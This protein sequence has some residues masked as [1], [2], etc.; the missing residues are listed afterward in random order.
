MI[1]RINGTTTL[2]E[3]V[4]RQILESIAEGIYDK[5]DMLPGE[6][7]LIARTGVSRIT[8]REALKRLAEM[9]VIETRKGKGSFVLVTPS[10]LKPNESDKSIRDKAQKDFINSTKARL[11]LEPE[12]AREAARNATPEDIAEMEKTLSR[13]GKSFKLEDSFDSFHIALAKAAHNPFIYSFVEQLVAAE[14]QIGDRAD[15]VTTYVLPENQG[16]ISHELS[17]QHRKI[18]EAVRDGDQEF[19]YF[20]MKEH[21]MYLKKAYEEFFTWFL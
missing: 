5:G 11:M 19:A 8:V 4:A 7:E 20:Y 16:K 15:D 12:I 13:K 2:Y 6:K 1:E 18:F 21:M 14:N 10:D 17:E 3:E 9:G